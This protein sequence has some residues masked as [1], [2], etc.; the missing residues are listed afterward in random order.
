MDCGG[1]AAALLISLAAEPLALAAH[2]S[3]APKRPCVAAVRH[4]M[5]G[6]SSWGGIMTK[7]GNTWMFPVVVLSIASVTP[8]PLEAQ[9]ATAPAAC[10]EF[11]PVGEGVRRIFVYRSHALTTPDSSITRALVVVHGAERAARYEFRS[12]LAGAFLA[13]ALGNTVIIAPRFM[14]NDGSSCTD[15]LRS[16]ELNWDCDVQRVDWRLGGMARN[17]STTSSFDAMDAILLRI[18]RRAEFPNLRAIVVAGHSAGGQF[19]TLYA[20]TNRVHDRLGVEVSYVV[21]NASAYAYLDD[22]RPSSTW[23]AKSSTLD[24]SDTTR[25]VFARYSGAQECPTYDSWP[26]G[27]TNRPLYA[28]RL[29]DAQLAQQASQRTV[30][31]L[32]SQLDVRPPGGFFG[33]C[34]AMPQGTTRL[35]RGLAFVGYMAQLNHAPHKSIIIDAC[36]HDPRCVYTSD[37]ALPVLFSR[38]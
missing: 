18:A 13:G 2:R 7:R 5:R 26:F 25:I 16:N 8:P 22:R 4:S 32:L 9:C 30:T 10:T 20:M 28:K 19:V 34:A 15:S 23:L 3:S 36:G 29:S 35:S 31:Y 1:F 21:A 11:V 33:S 38:R 6:I 24:P 27:L 17:D 37:D 12:A 14:T